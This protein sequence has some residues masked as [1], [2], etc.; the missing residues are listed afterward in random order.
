MARIGVYCTS[1][2]EQNFDKGLWGFYSGD[3]K[4]EQPFKTQNVSSE[5]SLCSDSG[6]CD[7][8]IDCV[9]RSTERLVSE[10]IEATS[11]NQM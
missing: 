10:I 8:D 2:G 7:V 4:M 3:K 6:G 11:V 9:T 5:K 1:Q